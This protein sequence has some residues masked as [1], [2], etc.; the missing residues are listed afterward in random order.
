[1]NIWTVLKSFED[2][3]SDKSKFFG[4]VKNEHIKE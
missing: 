2:E 3:Q 4:C 1:M